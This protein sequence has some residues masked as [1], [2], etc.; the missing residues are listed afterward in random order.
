MVGGV[1][2][3]ASKPH[4]LNLIPRTHIVKR[5]NYSLKLSSDPY[6]RVFA[7]KCTRAHTE[8]INK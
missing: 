5:S 6:T 3:L 4:G 8:H 7:C 1:K 2:G